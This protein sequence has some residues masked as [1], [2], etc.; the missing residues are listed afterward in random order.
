MNN[1][2]PNMSGFDSSDSVILIIDGPI[3]NEVRP[4]RPERLAYLKAES[5]KIKRYEAMR[6]ERESKKADPPQT[7]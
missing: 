5:E 4:C 3:D 1:P 7:S 2:E 6:K